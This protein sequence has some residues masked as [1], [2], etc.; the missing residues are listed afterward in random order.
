VRIGD[1]LPAA[2]A[3][4]VRLYEVRHDGPRA[5]QRH[6]HHDVVDPLRAA[7]ARCSG[8]A[9]GSRSGRSPACRRARSSGTSRGRPAA[10]RTSW[11]ARRCGA[12]SGRRRSSP[13]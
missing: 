12:R 7:S 8:S 4:G 5:D 10:G 1:L 13:P 2:A 3:A 9:R 11:G 6:L